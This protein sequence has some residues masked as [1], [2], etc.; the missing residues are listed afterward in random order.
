MPT[1]ETSISIAAPRDAVWRV[2]SNVAAWPEWLPTVTSVQPLDGK[3]LNVGN[4]YVVRQPKLRPATWRVMELEQP[5]RFAW[6]AQSPGLQMF[7]DHIVDEGLP[8]TSNVVLRFA[9]NGLLGGLVGRL[10]RSITESYLAKEAA[11]LKQ[12]VEASM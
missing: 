3:A 10:F 8:G 5:R 6:L 7:A 11:S 2:L 9:F 1:Y 4:R 12:N